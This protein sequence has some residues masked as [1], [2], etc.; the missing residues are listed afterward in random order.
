MSE[1]IKAVISGS[2]K[3]KPEI[4]EAID[5]FSQQGVW[6]LEST[7]G[8]LII[9]PHELKHYSA[10]GRLRPLPTEENLT[11]KQIE[12]RFLRAIDNSDFM[13]VMNNEGYI[14]ASTALEI[15]YAL[16]K[17][18]AFYAREPFNFESMN[19]YDLTMRRVLGET[20]T[21]LPPGDVVSHYRNR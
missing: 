16:P 17:A 13:Y 3:Y 5:E 8:W 2:F 19:I 21:V 6:V 18:V 11:A 9:P 4:D 12:D 7:K 10:Q 14:G 15:G 1:R 20:F